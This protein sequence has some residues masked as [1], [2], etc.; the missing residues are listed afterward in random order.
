MNL[1]AVVLWL[2]LLAA[3]AWIGGMVFIAAVL[4]PAT[5]GVPSVQRIELF[6]L[7]GRRFRA[8][9]WLSVVVLLATGVGNVFLRFPSLEYLVGSRYGLV[10]GTKLTFVTGM[11]VLA[12]LHDFVLGPRQVAVAKTMHEG[13]NDPEQRAA[14]GR[15]QRRVRLLAQVNL[16]LGLA[17]LLLAVSLRWT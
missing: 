9:G 3:V 1:A 2:H 10:L 14:Y 12:I 15:L 11:I 8:V 16:L 13:G 17:V 6:G 4:A 5:R 7:V